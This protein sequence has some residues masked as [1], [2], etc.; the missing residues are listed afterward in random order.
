MGLRFRKSKNSTSVRSAFNTNKMPTTIAQKLEL[1]Y[2]PYK[3]VANIALSFTIVFVV[4]CFFWIWCISLA[5][6]SFLL[7]FILSC[8]YYDLYTKEARKI[9]ALKKQKIKENHSSLS[10]ESQNTTEHAK[11]DTSLFGDCKCDTDLNS[12]VSQKKKDFYF[13]SVIEHFYLYRV[14]NE[15]IAVPQECIRNMQPFD[16]LFFFPEPT[17]E[18]DENAL[19][20]MCKDDFIGYVFRGMIQDMIHDFQKRNWPITA[21][22]KGTELINEKLFHKYT[23]AFYKDLCRLESK[24]F[25]LK[26]ITKIDSNTEEPRQNAFHLLTAGIPLEIDYDSEREEYLVFYEGE[27][28]EI[29]ELG[30]FSDD[31]LCDTLRQFP[32]VEKITCDSQ[33]KL[34]IKV[35]YTNK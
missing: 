30:V 34:I 31:T 28:E 14:Y 5:I 22:Y 23:I 32:I 3:K 11:K 7:Y 27:F 1:K 33:Y 19:K 16:E 10:V 12:T 15:S 4:L 35:Y 17:N 9:I 29:Y 24:T 20:I 8:M 26:G 18:Y 2:S 13:P 21:Y 25:T 6:A